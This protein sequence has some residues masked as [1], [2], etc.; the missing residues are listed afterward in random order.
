MSMLKNNEQ[1][2]NEV[3]NFKVYVHVNKIN[4][5]RYVGIT[6]QNVNKRW[7]NGYGYKTNIFG[8]RFK[9]MDGI[10]L[11]MKYYLRI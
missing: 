5:K 1:N 2:E 6:K 11:N 7:Q 10:I 4:G 9:S 8:E 3:R